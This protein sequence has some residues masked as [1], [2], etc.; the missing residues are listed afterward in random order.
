MD[1]LL[2]WPFTKRVRVTLM[3]QSEDIESRRHVSHVIDPNY[4][5]E[6][7]VQSRLSLASSVAS[8]SVEPRSQFGVPQFIHLEQLNAPDKY[9]RDDV[10]YFGVTVDN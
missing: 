9:I 1:E 3:D 4:D 6:D 5:L 10:V 7:C 2:D 8:S